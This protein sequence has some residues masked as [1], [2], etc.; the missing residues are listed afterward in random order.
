MKTGREIEVKL[1]VRSVP[2]IVRLIR[3]LRG[4]K[5]DGRVF[6]RNTLFDTAGGDYRRAGWLVRIRTQLGAGNALVAAGEDSAVVTAKAPVARGSRKTSRYKERMETEGPIQDPRA[7]EAS[8]RRLGLRS[9]FRYEKYRATF[10]WRG[11]HICLDETPAGVFVELEG[12]PGAIDRAAKT[13]G[14]APRDY[15]RGTYWDVYVADCRRRGVKVR[16][17]VFRRR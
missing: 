2:E 11:L 9:T 3:G 8:L 5:C 13:L 16:D 4:V 15:F 14:Y 17:M 12:A 7:L 10:R 1:R 6:E